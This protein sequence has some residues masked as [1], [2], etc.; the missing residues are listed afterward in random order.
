MNKYKSLF[1]YMYTTLGRSPG[2]VFNEVTGT[3]V[4]PKNIS[5]SD[6]TKLRE[7]VPYLVVDNSG[8]TVEVTYKF[9]R[10]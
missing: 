9:E 7:G 3:M 4:L 8:K 5:D 1:D 2:G 6:L 10:E